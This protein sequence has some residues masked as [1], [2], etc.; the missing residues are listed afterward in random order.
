M[1]TPWRWLA[2]AGMAAVGVVAVSSPAVARH[3]L[4]ILTVSAP[5]VRPGGEVGVSGYS[6]TQ[7]VSIR[8]N[9]LDGPV[10]G[11]FT[12]DSNSDIKGQVTVPAET[13]PGSYL[14]Y[15]V[16]GPPEKPSRLPARAR[17]TVALDGGG[18]VLGASTATTEPR[19]ADLIRQ[20]RPTTASLLVIGLGAGGLA[21]FLGGAALLFTAVA[22]RPSA[23]P[24]GAGR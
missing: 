24:V 15:A 6:Y 3:N 7:P 11:T 20:E 10:L 4:S 21:L 8:L 22:R 9:A 5:E 23:S 1:R 12:P 16:Q 19:V 18:P 2:L 14:L 13:K 17:I